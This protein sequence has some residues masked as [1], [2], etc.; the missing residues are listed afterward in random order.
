MHS[1]EHFAEKV[2]ADV[3]LAQATGPDGAAEPQAGGAIIE[4][5]M[6]IVMQ[7]LANCPMARNA[8]IVKAVQKPTLR[9][10][11]QFRAAVSGAC[12]QCFRAQF[13]SKAWDIAESCMK[14]AAALTEAE[15]LA[16]I[17]DATSTDFMVV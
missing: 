12:E 8:D 2:A 4:M 17:E 16:V 3:E 15:A 5:I 9:L 1:L 14:Q 6:Q 11:A 10:R 13:K 7:L